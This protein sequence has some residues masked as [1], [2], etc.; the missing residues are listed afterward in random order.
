[1]S[2]VTPAYQEEENLRLLL[3]RIFA[4]LES[5]RVS[6]E[7][8]VVDTRMPLDATRDV[9]AALNAR[10][11]ARRGG[12]SFGDA[13]RTGIS[14]ARGE[15]VIFM[16]SDGSHSP[17]WIPKL[18]A[19]HETSDVVI[20]SRY[21]DQGFTENSA[22]LVLMSRLLN[23]TYSVVL[24]IDCKDVSNSYRL[25]RRVHLEALTL[26]CNNFDVVEEVLFKL[27]RK[28]RP[29]RIREVPSTF[30]KRMFGTTKRNLLPFIAT[31]LFTLVKLR[32]FV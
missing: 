30:K 26:R 10:C 6:H 7:V 29:L 16:D 28:F 12:D 22:T 25:Y 21:V 13:I 1:L 3:P 5:L 9:C 31:Y 24:G 32:F 2:V 27:S 17:E 19:H 8:V 18:Y 15:Y 11:V 14:E 20:A 23:W 4:A